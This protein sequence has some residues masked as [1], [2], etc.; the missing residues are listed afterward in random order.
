MKSGTG[1]LVSHRRTSSLVVARVPTILSTRR[2]GLDHV[3]SRTISTATRRTLR[4]S[5]QVQGD[6]ETRH[7]PWEHVMVVLTN[8]AMSTASRSALNSAAGLAISSSE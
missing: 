1:L 2:V 5:S 7:G 3:A 6:V 8:S 4:K